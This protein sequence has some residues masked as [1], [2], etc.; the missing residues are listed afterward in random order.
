MV[1]ITLIK[2]ITIFQLA[3]F[4][5]TMTA[6]PVP[7]TTPETCKKTNEC[8]ESYK[9]VHKDGTRYWWDKQH[10]KN[11][12]KICTKEN[13]G[14]PLVR[15]DELVPSALSAVARRNREGTNACIESWISKGKNGKKYWKNRQHYD[16]ARKLCTIQ[17]EPQPLVR[18]LGFALEILLKR[19]QRSRE[20]EKEGDDSS[21]DPDYFLGYYEGGLQ[22]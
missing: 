5:L 10:Y 1:A 12:R 2:L 17:N 22:Q 8:I 19:E 4:L 21:P 20:D 6:L 9:S 18:T 7:D 13:E 15:K 3:G 16:D 14:Q 11:A